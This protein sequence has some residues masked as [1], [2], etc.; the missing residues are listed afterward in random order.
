MVVLEEKEIYRNQTICTF[1][2]PLLLL[3][4]AAILYLEARFCAQRF[5]WLLC[6]AW[7]YVRGAIGSLHIRY[8]RLH[9]PPAPSGA[10]VN[11]MSR[12]VD[13]FANFS[14]PLANCFLSLLEFGTHTH[15]RNHTHAHTHTLMNSQSPR[16]VASFR[17]AYFRARQTETKCQCLGAYYYVDAPFFPLL[18]LCHH[19]RRHFVIKCSTKV[20]KRN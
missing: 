14:L 4:V 18:T 20:C 19:Q 1:I 15:T 16:A 9:I 17:I 12:H 3:Y 8:P 11:S 5:A 10:N 2:L 6:N 7:F 13:I